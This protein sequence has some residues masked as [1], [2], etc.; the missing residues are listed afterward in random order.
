MNT[1]PEQHP[2]SQQARAA[3]HTGNLPAF[4]QSLQ[5]FDSLFPASAESSFLLGLLERARQH[6]K[7]AADAFAKAL[8]INPERYDAQVE[9]A[10]LQVVLQDPNQ[11][12]ELLGSLPREAQNSPMYLNLAGSVYSELAVPE[13]AFP[14]FQQALALQPDSELIRANL[15]ACAVFM[16]E[17]ELADKLYRELLR[18]YPL[19][20]RYHYYLARLAKARDTRHIDEMRAVAARFP[21]KRN[22]FI[23]FALGK[24]LED[25]GNYEES[26]ACYKSANDAAKELSG[27]RV[28]TDLAIADAVMA[29]YRPGVA[30]TAPAENPFS[31]Q[32]PIFLVGLPR[33]GTTLLE[34]IMS[35]HPAVSS[36][37]ETQYL[38]TA[39]RRTSQV[40][41]AERFNEETGRSL[42]DKPAL[43]LAQE[44]WNLT[45][46]LRKDT[47]FFIEKLPWNFL[48]IGFILRAIPNA[49][50]VWM[51]RQAED[52][53][54]AIY[55]QPFTWAYK[56][57]YNL[58]DLGRYYRKFREVQEY[59]SHHCGDRIHVA[60]YED[61][62]GSPAESVGKLCA[63]LGIDFD[64]AMLEFH[65][66]NKS[67]STTASS[68]QIR[69]AINRNS[70]DK[71]RRYE[72][73]LG[74]L[75][76]SLHPNRD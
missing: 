27:Y 6:P 19:H 36:I 54:F 12:M 70:V 56:Y 32:A 24:E 46:Y 28:E 42:L 47:P 7:L 69:S 41:T 18:E 53:C 60:N 10:A 73:W 52:S 39:I 63:Y 51:N 3:F 8:A 49:R 43:Q 30:G 38:D 65:E 76:S 17:I 20:Q 4:E 26:F 1:I 71:W 21:A 67:P 40:M 59:W 75:L 37:G 72:P 16:G 22:V 61:I 13:L 57:S 44:Y 64:P 74:E 34:R 14:L 55:K 15:A 50:I 29:S 48:Y 25:T 45:R 9:L 5:Q 31:G 11:A 62:T 23:N 58:T 33:S 68:V 35:S 2:L 66:Q